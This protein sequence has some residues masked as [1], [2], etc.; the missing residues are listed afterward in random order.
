MRVTLEYPPA[1]WGPP[2]AAFDYMV[3]LL[4]GLDTRERQDPLARERS[5]THE[6]RVQMAFD[7]FLADYPAASNFITQMFT[8]GNLLPVGCLG[9]VLRPEDRRDD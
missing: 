2:G 1:F 4:G 5:T 9:G 7:G 3:G 6:K 8:C